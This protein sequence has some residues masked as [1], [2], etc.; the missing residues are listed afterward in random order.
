MKKKILFIL[1]AVIILLAGC[2]NQNLSNE[3]SPEKSSLEEKTATATIGVRGGELAA[4]DGIS[5]TSIKVAIPTGAVEKDTEFSLSLRGSDFKVVTGTRAPIQFEISPDVNFLMPITA[6]IAYPSN[7]AMPVPY[8]IDASGNLHV[9][10]LTKIDQEG[11]SFK[12]FT[13]M[14][15]HGGTY[16]WILDK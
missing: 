5:G 6:E 11:V 13:M 12:G 9:V 14:T 1:P 8:L 7:K 2:T 10:S 3:K 16:S 15:F 4:S